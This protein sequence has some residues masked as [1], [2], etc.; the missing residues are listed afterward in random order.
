[1]RRLCSITTILFLALVMAACV[2]PP[3]G[4]GQAAPAPETTVSTI[5]ASA[6]EGSSDEEGPTYEEIIAV[7]ETQKGLITM[8]HADDTW[9]WEL[10]ADILGRE[11][12]WY[13]ELAKAP[14]GYHGE[15]DSL[16]IGR[17]WWA[18]SGAGT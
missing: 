8:H 16:Q 10:P 7:A 15:S 17:A 13:S 5:P 4:V 9:W 1:M 2:A 6:D 14:A 11:L 3:A 12:L 18:S